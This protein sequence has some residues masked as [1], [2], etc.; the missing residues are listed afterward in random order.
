MSYDVQIPSLHRG[1]DRSLGVAAQ[2]LVCA[3]EPMDQALPAAERWALPAGRVWAGAKGGWW[4][5]STRWKGNLLVDLQIEAEV[6]DEEVDGNEL[7]VK[8]ASFH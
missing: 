5:L 8:Q 7:A 2:T 1:A 6:V 4:Y 3:N